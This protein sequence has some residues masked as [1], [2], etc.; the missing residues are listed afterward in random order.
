MRV[1]FNGYSAQK[2]TS[3]RPESDAV[4]LFAEGLCLLVGIA[5]VHKFIA[6]RAMPHTR[7]PNVDQ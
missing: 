2:H 7:L 6:L 3:I 5:P 4:F 1:E